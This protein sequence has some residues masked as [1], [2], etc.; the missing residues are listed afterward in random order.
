MAARLASLSS[1]DEVRR[2]AQPLGQ[3]IGDGYVA[4][5]QVGADGEHPALAV[6]QPREADG[7]GDRTGVAELDVFEGLPE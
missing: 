6:D 5:A 2:A 1:A 4:P 7:D 3:Q